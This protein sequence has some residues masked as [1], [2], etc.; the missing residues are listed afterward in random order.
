MAEIKELKAAYD[1]DP[2]IKALIDDAK[3]I[4]GMVRHASTH[5]A[6]VVISKE[7]LTDLVPV[8]LI[9]DT[10]T[11]TQYD[12]DDLKELGILKMDFLGLRNLSMI[13]HAVDIIKHT[14]IS[15]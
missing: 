12:M 8:Q 4:E 5:A 10:Q 11:M 15:I 3:R 6:G 2:K 9:N 14:K 7:E 13:A 1:R